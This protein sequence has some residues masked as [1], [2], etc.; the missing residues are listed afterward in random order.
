MKGR[1]EPT[2]FL[3]LSP[4]IDGQ[5]K[6]NYSTVGKYLTREQAKFVS[7][8]TESGE[9]IDTETIQQELECKRQLDKID[10]T[11]EDTNLYKELI[12]INA[13]KLET[14]LTQME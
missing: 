13:E 11:S 8:K 14:V 3:P 2:I 1:N 6:G 5:E 12:E 9:I 10:D 7:K 4:K